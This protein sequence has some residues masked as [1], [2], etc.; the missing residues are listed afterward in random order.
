MKDDSPYEKVLQHGDRQIGYALV[1]AKAP[2][3]A[4]TAI[5]Y[6]Y[7]LSGLS[8]V[9][10]GMA[11]A[12]QDYQ[13]SV[14]C[15][16]RPDCG[17]TSALP[18]NGSS[19]DFALHR[20]QGHVQD[21]LTVL[22]HEGIQRVYC[23]AAC[24]GHP[25][26]VELC[27]QLLP[28]HAAAAEPPNKDNNDIQLQ[29]LTLVAP[30]VSTACPHGWWVARMGATSP[31]CVLNCF[32]QTAASLSPLLMKLF[33]RPSAMQKLFTPEEQ[34]RFGW[35]DDDFADLCRFA[36]AGSKQTQKAKSPEARLGVSD[37]WQTH[38]CDK[39]ATECGL[40]RDGGDETTTASSVGAADSSLPEKQ[41]QQQ[42]QL[43]SSFP[44]RI[45]AAEQDKLVS[46]EAVEWLA[47]RCY[48]GKD[49]VVSMVNT[50]H[51]HEV[52]TFFAGPPRNPVLLHHIAHEW[53]LRD[54]AVDAELLFGSE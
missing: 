2:N 43:Q 17:A 46:P 29:G 50:I 42:Q 8:S 15:V 30:F 25:Y 45:Y 47:N 18:D 44:I 52:M 51:S 49:Q 48:G 40:F 53:G 19:Q 22:R 34:R 16:D 13:C 9:V 3:Q 23:L 11:P 20:I 28:Q 32:T 35:T 54:A 14:L 36:V 4:S 21:V 33:L 24:L 31:L 6:F 5:V 37:V 39:F 12:L 27:R 7:P 38:V 1:R 26:A 10:T 41:Q